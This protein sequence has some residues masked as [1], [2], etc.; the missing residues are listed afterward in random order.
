MDP[1]HIKKVQE[2]VECD[3]KI[4]KYKKAMKEYQDKKQELE[5]EILEYVE[6]QNLSSFSLTIS[7]GQIKFAKR[8]VTQSLSIK[9]L[10]TALETYE[11]NINVESLIRHISSKLETKQKVFMNRRLEDPMDESFS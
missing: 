5:D 6:K 1:Q 9:T 11:D 8:S 3:N 4:L 7:D 10:R 2:W